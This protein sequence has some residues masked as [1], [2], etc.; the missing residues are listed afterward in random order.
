MHLD[1][2]RNVQELLIAAFHAGD[3]GVDDGAI[4]FGT[5]APLLGAL[6]ALFAGR[7]LTG[8]YLVVVD[9]EL[10]PHLDAIRAAV[11]GLAAVEMPSPARA[12]V[13]T[14]RQYLEILEYRSDKRIDLQRVDQMA[15]RI[16]AHRIGALHGIERLIAVLIGKRLDRAP[17]FAVFRDELVDGGEGPELIVIPAGEFLM[18]SPESEAALKNADDP[19]WDDEIV[20][21][22]GKRAMQIARRFALGRY[23]VTFEDYDAFLE[24]TKAER[25]RAKDE[26]DDQEWGRGQRPVIHVSWDD[27]Q[28]YC[29][30]LNRMTGL[31]GEFGYRLPSEAE[32]EYAC[33]AGTQTR[34][35][36]GDEWD[37]TKA[38]GDDSFEGGKTSPVGRYAPNSWGLHDMIGN[39]D[40][41]CADGYAKNISDLPPGGAPYSEVPDS[42]ESYRVLRGGSWS[43][44][45]LNLRSAIRDR[46]RPGDRYSSVGFRVART[47]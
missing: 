17:R 28:A 42:T 23:P 40:E 43:N 1:Q 18:G 39:V 34:R 2:L 26:A 14:L 44:N 15:G 7:G 20:K 5:L 38:N 22:Q 41:W 24:A 30:W 4:S 8:D 35:W 32:W 16:R 19:A 27:A 31:N 6:A 9:N 21:G 45:P 33:R 29:D 25:Q 11:R 3:G 47:L 36:W 10:A 37:P 13:D 46:D 12:E